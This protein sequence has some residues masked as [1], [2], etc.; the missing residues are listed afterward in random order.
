M[1]KQWKKEAPSGVII[2]KD[3]KDFL[4]EIGLVDDFLQDLIFNAF[5]TNRD[6]QISFKGKT[7]S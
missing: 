2:K 3:F 1:H 5:D 7:N 4:R 6:G